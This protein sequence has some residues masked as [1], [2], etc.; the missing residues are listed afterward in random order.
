LLFGSCRDGNQGFLSIA[1]RDLLACRVSGDY[2]IARLCVAVNNAVG[3][4][5]ALL[6]LGGRCHGHG[7]TLS[8]R[9][10][11]NER[12]PPAPDYHLSRKVALVK[13]V[14]TDHMTKIQVYAR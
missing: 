11:E 12:G 3:Y 5:A 6:G 7:S 4:V 1:T 8:E 13:I 9:E 10:G 14:H 2:N